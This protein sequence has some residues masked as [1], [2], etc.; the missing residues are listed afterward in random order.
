MDKV[1][2]PKHFNDEF[3]VE[4]TCQSGAQLHASHDKLKNAIDEIENM[5]SFI[6]IAVNARRVLRKTKH[7]INKDGDFHRVYEIIA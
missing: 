3:V 7:W 4:V 5:V 6:G 1:L 2:M